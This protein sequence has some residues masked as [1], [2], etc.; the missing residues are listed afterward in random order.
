MPL[1]PRALP[2]DGWLMPPRTGEP[3]TLR[4]LCWPYAGLGPSLFAAWDRMAPAGVAVYGVQA[5]GRQR[6]ARP[7]PGPARQ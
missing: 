3:A 1:Q 5:P 2:E 4:L 6:R 7:P